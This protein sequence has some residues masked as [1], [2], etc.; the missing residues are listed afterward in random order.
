MKMIGLF[1]LFRREQ[2]TGLRIDLQYQ[3]YKVLE[4]LYVLSDYSVDEVFDAGIE[5]KKIEG[6]REH[7]ND[8]VAVALR[9][10]RTGN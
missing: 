2:R 6:I 10:K 4:A 5:L 9:K 8:Y 1:D 7:V 3:E